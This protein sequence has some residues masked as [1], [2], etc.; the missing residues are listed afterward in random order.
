MICFLPQVLEVLK[1]CNQLIPSR[2]RDTEDTQLVLAKEKIIIDDPKYLA[3]FSADIL[4]AS[5]QVC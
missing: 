3:M 2:F 1:L 4:P 5:I